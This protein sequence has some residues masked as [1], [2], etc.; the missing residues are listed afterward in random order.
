MKEAK[1][2]MSKLIMYCSPSHNL[3]SISKWKNFN[4]KNTKGVSRGWGIPVGIA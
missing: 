4:V 2:S 1:G 3:A